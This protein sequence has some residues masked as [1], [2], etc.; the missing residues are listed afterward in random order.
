MTTLG[1]RRTIGQQ[2]IAGVLFALISL[3][4][5]IATAADDKPMLYFFT[6]K[7]CAPC[8]QVKH[9]IKQLDSEGYP[10]TTVDVDQHPDW[11]KAFR[12][13]HTPTLS[14][15]RNNEVL[16]WQPRPMR[17]EELRGW[18]RTIRFTP[19]PRKEIPKKQILVLVA[20][21]A[22]RHQPTAKRI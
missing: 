17:A 15:V 19:S 7:G 4:A 5:A 16:A 12:V 8:I 14:L 10:V 21:D 6:S 9:V 1:I 3:S 13:T 11:A 20:N 2:I 18:F 22:S